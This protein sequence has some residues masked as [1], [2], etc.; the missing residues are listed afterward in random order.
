MKGAL[1]KAVERGSRFLK[2]APKKIHDASIFYGLPASLSRRTLKKDAWF[3]SLAVE[4][5]DSLDGECSTAG[6]ETRI[7]CLSL[8]I[9]CLH[10]RFTSLSVLG[11]SIIPQLNHE[12]Y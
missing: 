11:S 2:G 3:D 5:R 6:G 1:K 4:D 8:A 10:E 12:L 9:T 7:S